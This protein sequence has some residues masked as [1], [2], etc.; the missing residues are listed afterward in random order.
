MEA[1]V[2]SFVLLKAGSDHQYWPGLESDLTFI[3]LHYINEWSLLALLGIL[4][5]FEVSLTG[6]WWLVTGRTP[7]CLQSLLWMVGAFVGFL[8]TGWLALI[9]VAERLNLVAPWALVL[10]PVWLSF[11]RGSH[12]CMSFF[13]W[14]LLWHSFF[15]KTCI[16]VCATFTQP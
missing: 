8:V 12:F 10:G 4:H 13:N 15:S 1:K 3:T 14:R 16:F 6:D 9:F 2:P 5:L 7:R 11:L